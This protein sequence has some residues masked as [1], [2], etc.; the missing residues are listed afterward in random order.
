MV[1]CPAV[2]DTTMSMII[3]MLVGSSLIVNF[4]FLL[5]LTV[6]VIGL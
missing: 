5:A 6:T 2:V 4:I 1:T 3:N